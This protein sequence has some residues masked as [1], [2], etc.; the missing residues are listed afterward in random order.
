LKY[1]FPYAAT[2]RALAQS[3]TAAYLRIANGNTNQGVA[4]RKWGT[5]PS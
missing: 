3:A 2:F 1:E 5:S 4:S